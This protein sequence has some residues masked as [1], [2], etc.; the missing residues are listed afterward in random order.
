MTSHAHA[1][2]IASLS[3]IRLRALPNNECPFSR[4]VEFFFSNTWRGGTRKQPIRIIA[5]SSLS[6]HTG[7]AI[8]L[9]T[10]TPPP[11]FLITCQRV[12][13]TQQRL[14]LS[15]S[16]TRRAPLFGV[17]VSAAKMRLGALR[18][19][20][21]VRCVRCT[22]NTPM[23]APHKR[24]SKHT[25]TANPRGS[26]YCAQT[27]CAPFKCRRSSVRFRD[28]TEVV[29]SPPQCVCVCVCVTVYMSCI[30]TIVRE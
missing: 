20:V 17:I 8:H 9:I 19:I 6:S 22:P 26:L 24:S 27:H 23:N 4:E 1:W 30:A 15:R 5:I 11:T 28:R 21:C 25:H 3:Y 13:T 7:A 14:S 12:R 10:H 2:L 16:P 29:A 18:Q